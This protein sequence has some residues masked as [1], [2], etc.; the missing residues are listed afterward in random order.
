M[1]EKFLNFSNAVGLFETLP[2]K[3]VLW[4]GIELGDCGLIFG[5]AKSGKTMFCENLAISIA[6][7]RTSF[8]D[9]PLEGGPKPVIFIG[10]EESFISRINRNLKQF[11]TLTLEEKDLM[12]Q[13]FNVQ[14][15]DFP[16]F[17]VEG[18]QWKL[19]EETIA[20][21][22]AEVVFI[23]SITR[24]NHG[25]LEDSKTAQEIMARL[26]SLSQKL[27]ITLILIHHTPKLQG[28]IISMDSIKGSSVFSQESDFAIGISRT[29][30]KHRYM[31]NI[32]FRYVNDDDDSVKEFE[33]DDNCWLNILDNV[34]EQKLI[35]RS[36]RRRADNKRSTIIGYF[37]K[38]SIK[39]HHL[40]SLVEDLKIETGL[41]DR[42]IQDY[43]SELSKDGTILNPEKGFYCSKSFLESGKGGEN[44]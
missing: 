36:D 29:E 34:D 35:N 19:L 7:G 27:Q 39:K 41:K 1:E 33:I 28:G 32:F 11:Q 21:S 17:I 18:Q 4:N 16:Q 6:V 2:P 44:E 8:F 13:N 12:N 20:N 31:K 5:P 26:R 38:N 24:M 22:N 10:L 14:N 40:E 42:R 23:D 25:K 3:K 9:Y 30:Q 15:L 43:L 37:E